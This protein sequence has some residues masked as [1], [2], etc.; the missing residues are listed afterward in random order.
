[1]KSKYLGLVGNM[2]PCQWMFIVFG[3]LTVLIGISPWW[4]L[5]ETPVRCTW[6][7]ER[8]RIISVQCLRDNRTG[9]KKN[10]HK[11]EQVLEALTNY[12]V[13][14]LLFAVFCH[15]LTN[16]LQTNFGI[17]IE[18]FGYN[19]Y[20]LVLLQIPVGAIMAVSMII[21]NFFLSSNWGQ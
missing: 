6:L 19:T 12:R 14:M 7:N 3:A 16:S 5:P 15:N 20:Q 1:M 4:I 9:V 11:K 21:I 13:W 18:G 10:H 2:F 17:I 8:E